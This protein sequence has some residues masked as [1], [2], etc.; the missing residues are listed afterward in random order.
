MQ[1]VKWGAASDVHLTDSVQL[2]RWKGMVP[3][4]TVL[5]VIVAFGVNVAWRVYHV[6]RHNPRS[7]LRSII[8]RANLMLDVVILGLQAFCEPLAL[9][10]GIP[11]GCTTVHCKLPIF[12][13]NLTPSVSN[14]T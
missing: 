5:C 2:C 10:S 14:M 11:H 9:S 8:V 12:N 4:M 6:V 13:S 3:D 1:L 7:L